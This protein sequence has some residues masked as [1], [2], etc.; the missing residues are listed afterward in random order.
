MWWTSVTLTAGGQ[1]S[2]IS[3]L[4]CTVSPDA[5]SG[6]A[7]TAGKKMVTPPGL[8]RILLEA[9]ERADALE[10]SVAVV[11]NAAPIHS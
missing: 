1:N 5:L 9:T 7:C 3:I 10:C 2:R 11:R 6:A 8:L 4:C